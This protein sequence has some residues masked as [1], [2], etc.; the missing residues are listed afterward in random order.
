MLTFVLA[1]HGKSGMDVFLAGS[2]SHKLC[3]LCA[4]LLLLIPVENDLSSDF[5]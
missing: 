1:T 5:K 4:T 3:N 2:F